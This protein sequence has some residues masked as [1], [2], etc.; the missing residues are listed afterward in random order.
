MSLFLKEKISR[1]MIHLMMMQC[2]GRFLCAFSWHGSN[3][4]GCILTLKLL[5]YLLS[6][7]LNAHRSRFW[8]FIAYILS[9]G[10]VIGGVWMLVQDYGK[11]AC[12]VQS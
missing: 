7:N 10:A 11:K 6:V 12:H 9:F 2:A 4:F 5:F 3:A 1:S 8:L